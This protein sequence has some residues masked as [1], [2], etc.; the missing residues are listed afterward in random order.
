MNQLLLILILL[1][2][3][4]EAI[5]GQESK[6]P[7]HLSKND[8]Y[9]GSASIMSCVTGYLIINPKRLYN[10][11][12]I[13]KLNKKDINRFDRLSTRKWSPVTD[14]TSD[15]AVGGL[16]MAVPFS[17]T[18]FGKERH[19]SKLAVIGTM[20]AENISLILGITQIT[21]NLVGRNRP[22]MYN[23]HLSVDEKIKA[24]EGSNGRNSFYSMHTALAFSSA[25]FLTKTYGDLYE[26]DYKYW[27]LTSIVFG[28]ATTI[29]FMRF[30][31]GQHYPTDVL[32]A[33]LI[34]SSVGYLIPVLHQEGAKN[35]SLFITLEYGMMALRF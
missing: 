30:E 8:I 3:Q 24:S 18:H 9:I 5:K 7:Y 29:G 27:L 4:I 16:L 20:Y 21:K 33:A 19:F 22:F 1:V 31:A 25:M 11:I 6:F 34:G 23:S 17:A 10:S 13:Q 2:A 26:K 15:W 32:T 14:L 12:E 35:L 28:A